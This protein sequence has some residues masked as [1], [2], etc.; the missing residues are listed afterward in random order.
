[1]N[2]LSTNPSD[3]L[4]FDSRGLAV[5]VLEMMKKLVVT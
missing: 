1:M 3:L 4:N 2:K 5:K